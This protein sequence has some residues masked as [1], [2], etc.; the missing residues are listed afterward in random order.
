[1][2]LTDDDLRTI[3]KFG[4]SITQESHV[5]GDDPEDVIPLRGTVEPHEEN[6]DWFN[7]WVT[8]GANSVFTRQVEPDGTGAFMNDRLGI[9]FKFFPLPEERR[10]V[11]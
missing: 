3:F 9:T 4:I 11:H 2:K 10:I 8:E 6:P 7:V 5:P 1:M